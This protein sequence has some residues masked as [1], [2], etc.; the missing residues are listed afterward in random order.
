MPKN[1]ITK[2]QHLELAI[3]DLTH[4]GLGVAHIE[5][6]PIFIPQA[7]PKELVEAEVTH[8]GQRIGYAELVKIINE[9]PD[10][11]KTV[12]DLKEISGIMPL[13]HLKYEAQLEFKR[14]QVKK[15]FQKNAGL[16]LEIPLPIE[17]DYPYGYRNKAQIPVRMVDGKLTTGFFKQGTHDFIPT[18]DFKIQDPIIDQA[19]LIVRD[20]LRK[21]QITAY[22]EDTHEGDVRHLVIRRGHYTGEIMVVL[23]TK[24]FQLPHSL[25][26]IED[27]E[28]QIPDLV[29]VVQNINPDKTNV[30]LGK[31]SMVRYGQDFYTDHL[32][33]N[34]F[35][36]SHQS[37]YQV[38]SEQTEKLYQ[39]ALDFAD[40]KGHEVVVDAYCGIGTIS[41]A[42]AEQA[43]QVYGIE[44]VPQAIQNARE[45]AEYNQIGNVTF[46]TGDAEK[47]MIDQQKR[48][49]EPDVIVVDPP[50]K[51]LAKDFIEAAIQVAP[52]KIVYISCNPATQARDIKVF[53]D[54]GYQVKEI[55]L[56]DMFPQSYHV[57]SVCFLS[58]KDK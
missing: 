54:S 42:L 21:Y 1:K 30:I 52:G 57:E 40:L 50:R 39:V 32:M 49:L 9:S 37:F 26:I 16:D 27:L 34:K 6:Y 12:E 24:S 23:V 17:M 44:I 18:E 5:A 28:A 58:R 48:G 19:I 14:Q 3:D 33:G 55:Q 2:G 29:S 22:D 45:N 53:M 56:V 20:T 7:L 47:W 4:K 11:Q 13:G 10:R 35:K 36:I 15:V 43:K 25:E 46:E 8:L 38:N 41:L 51:G 31:Q